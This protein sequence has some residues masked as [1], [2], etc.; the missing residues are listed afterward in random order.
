MDLDDAALEHIV[1]ELLQHLRLRGMDDIAEIHMVGHR[2]GEGNLDRFRNR[3]RRLA[4]GKRQRNGAGICP[5]CHALR[6]AGVRIAAND[7]RPVIDG[8]VV[9]HLVD[10]IRHRVVL[11]FRVAAG[12]QAEIMHELHQ[13][14]R[15][16]G[17]FE[18]PDRGRVATRLVG[19]VDLWRNDGGGHRLQFLRRHQAGG[20]L[21]ANDID[22]HPH[23]RS[24]VKRSAGLD[25]DG[26]GIEDLFHRGHAL[27]LDRNF[28]RW[29]KGGFQRNAERLA[30]ESLQHFAEDDG[31]GAAGPDE[32]QLLRRKGGGHIDKLFITT[33]V[34]KL[35]V[36]C[37]DC[38][39]GTGLDRIFL[40]ENR[41][42]IIVQDRVAIAI[43]LLDPVLQID[44]NAA[45]NVNRCLE[46]RRNAIGACH[47][48]RNIDE[49]HV[50]AGLPAGPQRDIVDAGHA[51][52]A[53][54]HGAFFGDQH[55]LPAGMLKFQRVD[56]LLRPLRDKAF[57]MKFPVRA[58]M[59]LIARRQ[60]VGGNI[61]F[62]G[63]I[64]NDLD[65]F[66][67][68]RK[69][70]EEF[71]IR[72]AFKNVPG[73]G[74]AGLQRRFQTVLVS[75]IEE[76]LGL[77]HFGSV[78]RNGR[79][80][81]KRQ[82]QQ[83]PDRWA[84]LHM[85]Q[86]LKR[87]SRGDFRYRGLAKNNF[88]QETRLRAGR[89]GCAGKRVVDQEFERGGAMRVA[90]ILDL[91]DKLRHQPTIIDRLWLQPLLLAIFDLLEISVK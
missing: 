25:T 49:G 86:Q 36:R 20:V 76:D 47:D 31:V 61:S 71:R 30:G 39:D 29:S 69:A 43:Q 65:F 73:D 13:F 40:L 66:I 14:R 74:I 91:R 5:E 88:L 84:T 24:R 15:V 9:Q 77:Q 53:D 16:L 57:A 10:D 18:V 28:L 79:I 12:D 37:V 11:V 2:A 78:G 21:R 55:H 41:A 68:A 32:F 56:L 50:F 6:H 45:G 59:R 70:G 75:L 58:R 85:R 19:T 60:Q 38:Q 64:G 4:G 83:N 52:R 7:D 48:W 1:A 8:D 81:A 44:A 35:L 27:P 46:D 23:I 26:I 34:Q 62:S 33:F 54:T 89:A 90:A 3:H 82:I 17:G 22:P 42:L 67:D 51:G 63:D 87:E 80:I 72:I